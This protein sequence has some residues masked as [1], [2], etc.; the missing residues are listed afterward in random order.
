M[1]DEQSVPTKVNTPTG[2]SV[3]TK[4][5]IPTGVKVIS[6]LYYIY[7]ALGVIAGLALIAGTGMIGLLI[8]QISLFG[9]LG[10]GMFAVFGVVVIG[11]SV[12]GF[13]V[14]RGLRKAKSWARIVAIIS[15]ALGILSLVISM[16][17]G[18]II[19]NILG[20]AIQLAIGGYLLFNNNVKQTF[21]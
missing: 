9:A 16:I 12:L 2:V 10:A 11:L 14:A 3:P 5:N 20:L 15:S 6:V 8:S 18:N 19:S 1:N 13:F 17:R 7:A 21:A 4:V